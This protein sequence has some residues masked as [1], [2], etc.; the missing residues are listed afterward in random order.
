MG[1]F[2]VSPGSIPYRNAFRKEKLWTP[3][4]SAGN[5]AIGTVTLFTCGFVIIRDIF[6]VP[7]GNLTGA[8][9]TV[10]L[11][12]TGATSAFNAATVATTLTTGTAWISGAAVASAAQSAA[13]QNYVI[14]GNCNII[15]T[16]AVAAVTGGQMNF[17]V[18]YDT[19]SPFNGD[20]AGIIV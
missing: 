2:N 9:A 19:I 15:V 3:D 11:G 1:A 18:V 12:V 10:A 13:A 20:N 17:T 4:G 16:I 5:G 8:T 6:A 14:G 7:E